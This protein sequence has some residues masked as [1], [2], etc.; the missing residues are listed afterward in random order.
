MLRGIK[1]VV[2]RFRIVAGLLSPSNLSLKRADALKLRHTTSFETT[3]IDEVQLVFLGQLISS[4]VRS[5]P[6]ILCNDIRFS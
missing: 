2:M 1:I 6:Q 3:L 5:I 4:P